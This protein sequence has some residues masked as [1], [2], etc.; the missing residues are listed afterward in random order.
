MDSVR[1]RAVI[2][3]NWTRVT[4]EIRCVNF[5][6]EFDQIVSPFAQLSH[7][8]YH[9]WQRNRDTFVRLWKTEAWPPFIEPAM[10]LLAMGFG[11]GAFVQPIEGMSYMQ[12]IAPGI[13]A[14]AAMWSSSF[15]C[16]YGSFVR[17]EFQK[18]YDAMIA[19]PVS[20]E[21]VIAGE[22]FWGTT[23]AFL[24]ALA[25]FMIVSVLGL[26]TFPSSLGI[27]PIVTLGGLAFASVSMAFTAITPSIYFFN[28]FVT[29]GLTP[30]FLFAGV[31]YPISILPPVVQQIAW[32]MPLTH[33]VQP[34]RMLATG[35]VDASIIVDLVWLGGLAL[36]GFYLALILMRRRLIK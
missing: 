31:F 22:I 29:L 25:V 1:S 11:L 34:S 30:M 12:F 17:M 9:V 4:W 35:V 3:Y 33:M 24:S 36:T 20:V 32:F 7:R 26:V 23:R 13:V 21:D 5:Q 19:T 10:Y 28:Y 18:T 27:L 15:E 6:L 14:T 16:L 8:F 2:R